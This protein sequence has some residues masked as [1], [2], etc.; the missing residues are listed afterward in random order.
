MSSSPATDPDIQ[1]F[2]DTEKEVPVSLK[3]IKKAV[4][5]LQK[6][7]K[8]RFSLLE[9]VFVGEQKIVSINKKHLDR[10]YVTDTITFR[11]DEDTSNNSIEGTLFCCAPRIYEQSEELNE[12]PE[13]EFLRI[14]IHGLLH[15]AGYEDSSESKK[16]QMTE[17][18]DY[19]LKLLSA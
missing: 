18:E 5:L 15:L 16:N 17:R 10:D 6:E 11:Y 12:D 1:L 4:S 19:Y 7:E 13:K 8:C 2:N 14:V 9:V 3:Q